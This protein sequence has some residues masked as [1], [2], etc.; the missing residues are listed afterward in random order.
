MSEGAE[1]FRRNFWNQKNIVIPRHSRTVATPLDH[2]DVKIISDLIPTAAITDSYPVVGTTTYGAIKPLNDQ[3]T[4]FDAYVL[5]KMSHEAG[6]FFTRCFF[7]KVFTD[8]EKKTPYRTET[9]FDEGGYWHLLV[10]GIRFYP[11]KS[12]PRVAFDAQGKRVLGYKLY[13]KE[14]IVPAQ[15]ARRVVVRYFASDTDFVIPFHSSPVSGFVSYMYDGVERTIENCLHH[16]IVIRPQPSGFA[17]F[18]LTALT[19]TTIAGRIPGQTFKATEPPE[20]EP[21]ISNDKSESVEGLLFSRRVVTEYPPDE[22]EILIRR[23]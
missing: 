3:D 13:P 21:Y 2:S 12:M 22:P 6:T 15:K 4:S 20:W 23:G 19:A 8:A 10:K 17:A 7:V 14:F 5:R 16:K 11:D 1:T 9:F 18:D